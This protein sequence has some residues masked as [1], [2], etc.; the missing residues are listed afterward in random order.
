MIKKITYRIIIL[1]ALVSFTACQ[2]DDAPTANVDAMVAEPGDLLN[3][4]FPLNKV[5]VEGEGL[6]GLKKITLDNKID[7]SFNPNYNSDKAFIFT[8]PF[9]EK[10]GSRFG[11][12]PITFITGSGSVT[13]NIEILQPVPTITK[14]TPAVA[15]PGFPLEIEGTWFYNISSITLGGKTLSYTLK[16]STSIIIGLPSDAVTGSEL[17]VTTPGGSAKKTINFA[18]VVLVSDFDGNGSRRDWTAYG[19]IDSFNANTTGGPSGSYA[20]LVWA[21]STANGYNG[22]SAGGGASFL[23]AS[24]NDASKTFIDIDVSANVVGAQFAI[25]LNTID[26]VNYGY[27]F[28]VTDVNWATKTI[29]LSDFKDNYGFGSNTA[30]TVDPSKINEIKVGVAQGDSPNP[31]AIKYDNIKIRYQ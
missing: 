18:T 2:N 24:N 8:I 5:R 26:G 6:K 22:S 17:V 20:T 23:N 13:K 25:Q 30:A 16:S 4:A 28:K 14:T 3:Q 29:L 31:S 12:Q 9:D 27:N 19:D 21:G 15:T 7:I 10:L 11:V 1:L